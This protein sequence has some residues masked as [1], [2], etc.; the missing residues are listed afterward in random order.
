MGLDVYFKV[1]K[2]LEQFI[3]YGCV[4]VMLIPPLIDFLM[5]LGCVDPA[6]QRGRTVGGKIHLR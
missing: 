2:D 4:S 1:E 3:R 6:A 5:V